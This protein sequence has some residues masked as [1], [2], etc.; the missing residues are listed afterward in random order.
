MRSL[1]ARAYKCLAV[2]HC[3]TLTPRRHRAWDAGFFNSKKSDVS[4]DL[5]LKPLVATRCQAGLASSTCTALPVTVLSGFLGAGKTTLLNHVLANQAGLKLAVLVND[6]SEVNI[7]ENL[8]KVERSDDRLVELSNGC[9]CC[10]L[11]ED[12]VEMVSSLAGEK[13]FDYLLIE[14]TGISEPMPVAMTFAYR[15]SEGKS[16]SD[17]ARLDAMVTV[18]DA[19]RF[20]KDIINTDYLEDLGM[21]AQ[22]G[23]E[24]T[25]S[26]LLVEQA[27]FADVLVINK[28]DLVSAAELQQLRGV[29]ARLNPNAKVVETSKGRVDVQAVV[30]TGLF[31]IEEAAS[32]PGWMQALSCDVDFLKSGR[33]EADEYGVG[34]FVYRAERPFHP[35][36]L[37]DALE[38]E[39]LWQGV[40]RSKGFFWVATRHDIMGIWHSAGGAWRSEPSA[41]WQAALPEEEQTPDDSWHEVWGD[42]CQEIVWIGVQMD[43]ASLRAALDECLL[44]D[45]E[46]GMGPKRWSEFDDPLP[47]WEVSGVE[48]GDE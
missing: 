33:S 27:E 24:R 2:Q 22:E 6:M 21:Q 40:L 19:Q 34:S 32:M 16:L 18:V 10:T 1:Y 44:T 36:R 45:Q 35:A 39:S 4:S 13:Q 9:I 47:H 12:L 7:D 37:M 25:L 23:D 41:L 31:N 11:R 15:D 29:L 17:V 46:M 42:R 8:V 20:V 28:T 26:D 3:F 14:S 43:E 38:V 5:S 48:D 30:G